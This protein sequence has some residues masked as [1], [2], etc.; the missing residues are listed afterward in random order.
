MSHVF[1]SFH[2]HITGTNAQSIWGIRCGYSS[3]LPHFG[4]VQT[5]ITVGPFVP[6]SF[7]T[8]VWTLEK[9]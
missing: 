4:I 5:E 3:K 6:R 2:I 8:P 1:I 9:F 7:A